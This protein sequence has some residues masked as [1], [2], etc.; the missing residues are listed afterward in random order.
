[1][2]KSQK[3]PDLVPSERVLNL[4]K[5]QCIHCWTE[6]STYVPYPADGFTWHFV[7]PECNRLMKVRAR[8]SYEIREVSQEEIDRVRS[9][10]GMADAP[11]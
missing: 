11:G 10:G 6:T 7:C 9:G 3:R 4:K 8:V 5:V 1:M 2:A